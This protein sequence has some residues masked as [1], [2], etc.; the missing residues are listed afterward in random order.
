MKNILV[1]TDFSENAKAAEKYAFQLA[2]HVKGNL[3]LYNTYSRQR[4]KISGNVVWPHS[5]PSS[6]LQ[7]ISNLQARVNELN[8]DL[9]KIKDNIHKPEIRHLGNAGSLAGKLNEIIAE[10]DIWLCVMGTKGESFAN[11]VLFGSNV[12][13][14]LE[15]I[16]CPVLIIPKEAE[17][18]KLKKIGYATDFRSSD[19][20]IIN[21]L[22]KLADPLKIALILVHVSA[23]TISDSEKDVLRSQEKIYKSQFPGTT[24]QIF[25]GEN[26]QDSLH[27]IAEQLDVSMLALLHRR[28]EFFEGLFQASISRKMIKHT[29]IPVLIF[30]DI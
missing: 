1:L 4:E 17:Y 29:A 10:N 20:D 14:V 26:I 12:F 22:Y 5:T 13:K 2:I 15:K 7:S 3:I 8:H 30:R 27:K 18:K 19:V 6:E 23:D 11:N 24:I 21:W 28:Q 25:E 16:N 9:R